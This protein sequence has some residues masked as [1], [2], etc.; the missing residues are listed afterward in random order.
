M[1]LQILEPGGTWTVR[2][3]SDFG[4]QFCHNI[5]IDNTFLTVTD[6]TQLICGL[7]ECVMLVSLYSQQ[8]C[9]YSFVNMLPFWRLRMRQNWSLLLS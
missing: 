4:S 1:P 3:S 5:S 9:I 2:A 7:M 8:S 6:Y